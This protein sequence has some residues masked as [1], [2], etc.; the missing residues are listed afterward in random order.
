MAS[1]TLTSLTDL[2]CTT[3]DADFHLTEQ[4]SDFAPYL[5]DP[6]NK[7]ISGNDPFNE[8]ADYNDP[9]PDAGIAGAHIMTGRS[10]I[11]SPDAV[12]T[13]ED[14]E[15][16]LD[17]L[18]VN[19]PLITPGATV[20]KLGAV[21]N[22]DMAVA[23]ARAFNEFALDQ[24]A[25]ESD[26][27]EV[28]ITIAGQRPVAAAE[29]ID[30]RRNESDVTCVFLPSAG[31]N[32]P[33]GHEWWDPMWEAIERA[34]LPLVMH[35]G[36]GANTLK[37][38]PVQ[39]D[40]FSTPFEDHVIGHPFQHIINMVSLIVQGIPERYDVEFL[41]QESGIGWIPYIAHRMDNE[42][43][44]RRQEAPLL[45]KCPSEYIF[46][47]QFYYSSQPLEGHEGS[48]ENVCQMARM[49]G[50]ADNLMWASDYPHHDFDHT[51]AIFRIFA[52]EF[53]KKELENIFGRT[54]SNVF[55]S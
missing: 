16:G 6:Y 1:K 22:D 54:A 31:V 43:N 8:N 13:V 17:L 29:E 38:F 30:E 27:L 40:W 2:D 51:D 21:H 47:D 46:G 10:Q 24:I 5:E 48:P 34:D 18:G 50:A 35:N 49:L 15:E 39:Y 32:P 25:D 53:N 12:R 4:L 7:M 41:F 19:Q 26:S 33:L 20:L 45:T 36:A 11:F 55:F 52:K 28:P 3:V 42:Y 44:Q 37:S 14:I 23:I 9:F